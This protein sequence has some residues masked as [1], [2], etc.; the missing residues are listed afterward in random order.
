MAAA[1][2][3]LQEAV[4]TLYSDH[5]G[6]LYGWLRRKLGNAVDAADVT[7]DTYLRIIVS[8]RAPQQPEQSRAFLAQIANGLVIDARRRRRLEAAYREALAQLPEPQ[9]PSLE[10]Q[11]IVMETLIDIDAALDRLPA[12]AR[13]AFVLSQF[14]GLTYSAIAERLGVSVGAVRK[15]MLKAIQ[16]CYLA[17]NA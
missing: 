17:L 1:D 11:A 12:K 16:V 13:E 4:H 8:G 14:D 6:W 15:Y 2:T 7:H 3:T 10:T 9:L 5:H